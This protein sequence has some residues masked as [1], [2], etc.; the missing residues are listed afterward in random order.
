[1]DLAWQ[2]YVELAAGFTQGTQQRAE[3]IVR[4]LVRRGEAEAS[5]GERAVEDLFD[6]VEHNCKAVSTVVKSELEGMIRQ[7]GLAQRSDSDQDG[8]R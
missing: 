5:K 6:W 8:E 2:R 3:E 7:L 4:A 1:M